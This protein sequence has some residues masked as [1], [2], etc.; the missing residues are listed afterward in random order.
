MHHFLQLISSPLYS[1]LTQCS[2]SWVQEPFFGFS[3]DATIACYTADCW[4]SSIYSWSKAW[5][6]RYLA[7]ED[8]TI[9]DFFFELFLR[10]DLRQMVR[11]HCS[12]WQ[13]S[14][15]GRAAKAPTTKQQLSAICWL[16]PWA[17]RQCDHLWWCNWQ[18]GGCMLQCPKQR[19][20]LWCF[21]C[22]LMICSTVM[23]EIVM[24]S[25]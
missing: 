13:A 15:F 19:C 11:N 24:N 1:F 18:C 7:L 16:I 4:P 22:F 5:W 3:D 25:A 10:T 12:P 9:N 8:P 17:H 23:S 6:R 21:S 20:A 2:Y 14:M